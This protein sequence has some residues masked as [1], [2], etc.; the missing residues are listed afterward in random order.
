MLNLIVPWW[1]RALAVVALLAAVAGF[2]ALKMRQHDNIRYEA[3]ERE[4]AQFRGRVAAEGAAAQARAVAQAERDK[5]RKENAD[6]DHAQTVAALDIAVRGL[7]VAADNHS[8]TVPAAPS[9]SQ[10]PDLACFDRGDYQRAWGEDFKRLRDGIRVL[11]DE[12]AACTV[13]LDAAKRWAQGQ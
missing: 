2:G 7:R 10:R 6:K 1:G 8:F 3:L 4:Y 9:G 5:R 12:G 13:G 11:L